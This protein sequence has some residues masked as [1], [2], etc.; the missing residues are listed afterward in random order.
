[1]RYHGDVLPASW[2]DFKVAI[3]AT[4]ITLFSADEEV[5]TRR[6]RYADWRDG[7]IATCRGDSEAESPERAKSDVKAHASHSRS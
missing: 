6:G 3:V 2:S 5:R 1:M 7:T 4:P